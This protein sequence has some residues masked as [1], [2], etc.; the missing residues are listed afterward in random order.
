[1]QSIGGPR[2]SLPRISSIRCLGRQQRLT[3]FDGAAS[4]RKRHSRGTGRPK[5]P[6]THGLGRFQGKP[7]GKPPEKGGSTARL[8]REGLVQIAATIYNH[9]SKHNTNTHEAPSSP[10]GYYYFRIH[11]DRSIYQR[12]GRNMCGDCQQNIRAC[13]SSAKEQAP[14]IRRGVYNINCDEVRR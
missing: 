5:L 12:R 3:H 1:M 9:P 8:S 14:E 2:S 10:G 6:C 4:H 7:P 11:P 13:D